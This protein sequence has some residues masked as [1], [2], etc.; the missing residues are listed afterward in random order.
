MLYLTSFS[1]ALDLHVWVLDYSA[2]AALLARFTLGDQSWIAAVP[3]VL[4][5]DTYRMQLNETVDAYQSRFEALIAPVVDLTE[6]DYIY[7]F[8]RG[9]SDTLARESTADLMSAGVQSYVNWVQIDRNAE[10]RILTKQEPSR[11]TTPVSATPMQNVV[12]ETE[13]M[14]GTT[15]VPLSPATMDPNGTCHANNAPSLET[16]GSAH[17]DHEITLARR[18]REEEPRSTVGVCGTDPEVKRQQ[19]QDKWLTKWECMLA[20]LT[21]RQQARVCLRCASGHPTRICPLLP[22]LILKQEA[23][24]DTQPAAS[25]EAARMLSQVQEM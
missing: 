7:W 16:Q 14:Y 5:F 2:T 23:T 13:P 25:C 11:F 3:R 10:T 4:A 22:P 15:S 20:E 18:K 21:W 17:K 6:R 1:H 9:I 19:V 12:C 8:Q 24:G